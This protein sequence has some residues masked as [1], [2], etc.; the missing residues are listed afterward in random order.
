M[1]LRFSRPRLIIKSLVF[2]VLFALGVAAV[3]LGAQA[4]GFFLGGSSPHA[5]L[6]PMPAGMSI[7]RYRPMPS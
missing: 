3:A 1:L 4:G 5:G 2:V 6:V 7:D